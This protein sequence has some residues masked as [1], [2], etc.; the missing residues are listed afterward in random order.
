[1]RQYADTDVGRLKLI[2]H[3]MSPV[4]SKILQS[5]L[6]LPLLVRRKMS[7][8][9][10][11][12]TADHTFPNQNPP[13]QPQKKPRHRH[14]PAQLAALNQL[15]DQNEHPP[16]EE[17]TI[18]A[19]RLGM[20]VSRPFFFVP[21]LMAISGKQRPSMLGFKINEPLQ[22]NAYGVVLRPVRPNR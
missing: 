9:F 7:P 18:L 6:R 1:M 2:S 11:S 13:S 10:D 5:K 16:L 4:H 22:R 19:E 21:V 8:P 17:R 15:F 14:S 20:Y 12:W 3:M